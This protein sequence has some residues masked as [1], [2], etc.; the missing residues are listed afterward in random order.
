MDTFPDLWKSQTKTPGRRKFRVTFRPTRLS[1]KDSWPVNLFVR[2]QAL[3]SVHLPISAIKM[4]KA[5]AVGIPLYDGYNFTFEDENMKV[6]MGIIKA[7]LDRLKAER[8]NYKDPPEVEQF[9][10]SRNATLHGLKGKPDTLRVVS[11]VV[12]PLDPSEF[13]GG[14]IPKIPEGKFTETII[15]SISTIDANILENLVRCWPE[16]ERNE[17]LLHDLDARKHTLGLQF[18]SFGCT[19]DVLR[20]IVPEEFRNIKMTLG[21]YRRVL[22]GQGRK[23]DSEFYAD[24]SRARYLVDRARLFLQSKTEAASMAT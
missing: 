9:I 13:A 21:G 6:E 16:F 10:E 5:D 8:D 3:A 7:E 20:I 24:L 17:H 14:K 19:E 22:I 12:V 1:G 4:L 18:A 15:D 2:T 23:D 11:R